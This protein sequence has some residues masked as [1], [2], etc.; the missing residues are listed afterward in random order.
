MVIKITVW[1]IF[2]I[3]NET[4]YVTLS[5]IKTRVAELRL[6]IIVEA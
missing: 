2:D 3:T 6:S 4:S 1:A 5:L